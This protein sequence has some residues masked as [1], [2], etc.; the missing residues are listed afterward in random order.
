MRLPRAESAHARSRRVRPGD[1]VLLVDGGGAE[2]SARVIRVSKE[3]LEVAVERVGEAKAPAAPISLLVAA[4]RLERLSWIVEK[5]TELGASRLVLLA[6]GRTQSF[7]ATAAVS[8]RLARVARAAAKQSGAA[9]WPEIAGPIA[10]PEAFAAET[11]PIRFVLDASGA[12]FPAALAPAPAAIA[13]GPEGGW[14]PGELAAA[15]SLGWSA[16]RLPAGTLRAET[17]AVA[18]LALLRAAR[19]RGESAPGTSV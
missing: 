5:A 16:A 11:A 10:A 19:E 14:A 1:P 4:V 8:A 3:G 7:R 13:I 6:A 15:A 18:A 9:A 2:A 17:A 12:S